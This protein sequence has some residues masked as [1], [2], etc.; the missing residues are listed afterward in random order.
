MVSVV[1][2]RIP[3]VQGAGC[4]VS[5]MGIIMLNCLNICIYN[6][7]DCLIIGLWDYGQIFIFAEYYCTGALW[8]ILWLNDYDYIYIYIYVYSKLWTCN[9]DTKIWIES[10][11][12]HRSQAFVMGHFASHDISF[13]VHICSGFLQRV[14]V[15]LK[16]LEIV[17]PPIDISLGQ[18]LPNACL[19]PRCFATFSWTRLWAERN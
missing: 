8:W 7:R 6:I 11:W 4:I 13:C 16:F 5:G 18:L 10:L 15:I 1:T 12:G 2:M 3:S 14:L 9:G 19:L 17:G